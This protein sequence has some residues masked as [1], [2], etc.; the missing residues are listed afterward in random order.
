MREL[1]R[2]LNSLFDKVGDFFDI[3]DLSFFVAGTVC[4]AA[5]AFGNHLGGFVH[6]SD[7]GYPLVMFLVS[8]YVL[9]LVCFAG[10]RMLRPGRGV[11]FQAEFRT[12]VERHG[13]GVKY[14]EY[15]KSSTDA[16]LLYN[17]FWAELRQTR[18][19]APSFSLLRRYW[20]MAATCDGLSAALTVW[21]LVLLYWCVH[22][23]S[24][25]WA[26]RIAPLVLLPLAVLL[27]RREA[28]RLSHIQVEELAATL[29]CHERTMVAKSS[30][31]SADEP[32]EQEPTAV[33]FPG[34]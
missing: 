28:G 3:F 26:L 18:S 30:P 9:G 23:E 24:T 27:C 12:A 31:P 15:L 14:A 17:R 1:A 11:L 6:P 21:W 5:L 25:P 2:A 33:Q 29:A 4:F 7:A 34:R 16:F 13:L 20:S 32:D 22:V 8:C 10:G 19:L